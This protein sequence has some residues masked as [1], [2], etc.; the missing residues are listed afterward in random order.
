MGPTSSPFFV[1]IPASGSGFQI[2]V[3]EK[4]ELLPPFRVQRLWLQG[5]LT[6][7]NPFQGSGVVP[8]RSHCMV[9]DTQGSGDIRQGL[10]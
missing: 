2:T 8:S 5:E 4:D 9:Q 10:R 1:R 3:I 7:G 6:F